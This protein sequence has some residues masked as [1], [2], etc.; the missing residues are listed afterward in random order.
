VVGPRQFD[1]CRIIGS[2]SS[3]DL[4]IILQ[5][6]TLSHLTTRLIAPVIQVADDFAVDRSTPAVE[7]NGRRHMIAVHLLSPV[8]LR[9]LTI[10]VANAGHLEREIKNAIDMVFFGV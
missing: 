4:A 8:P 5:D 7:L 3:V 1:V 10:V 2:R 9:S 6:D